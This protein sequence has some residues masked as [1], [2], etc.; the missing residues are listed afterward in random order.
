MAYS[1]YYGPL[2]SCRHTIHDIRTSIYR[3]ITLWPS[4]VPCADH[5]R[6]FFFHA[7][8]P[9]R[10]SQIQ[11]SVY[12]VIVFPFRPR[13]RKRINASS[14]RRISARTCNIPSVTRP[15]AAAWSPQPHMKRDEA[16]V[17]RSGKSHAG[18]LYVPVR[19]QMRRGLRGLRRRSTKNRSLEHTQSV[20]GTGWRCNS[21]PSMLLMPEF[22]LQRRAWAVARSR[23]TIRLASLA[24]SLRVLS[25]RDQLPRRRQFIPAEGFHC[26]MGSVAG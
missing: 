14:T 25:C 21:G 16:A 17:L 6:H 8:G 13:T 12:A 10:L 3:I 2:G 24:D 9:R 11:H 20:R 5:L 15:R 23:D 22:Q 19:R 4:S 18:P 7:S 1:V 26:A